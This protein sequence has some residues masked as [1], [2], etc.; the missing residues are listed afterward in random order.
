[1]IEEVVRYFS[2]QGNNPCSGE[3]AAEVMRVIDKITGKL[4]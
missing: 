3:D 2:D 1:M 4:S